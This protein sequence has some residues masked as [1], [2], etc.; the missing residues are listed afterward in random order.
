MR[1]GERCLRQPDPGSA[2][3]ESSRLE[4]CESDASARQPGEPFGRSGGVTVSISGQRCSRGTG[5][6][7]C[8]AKRTG[9]TGTF[10]FS[11]PRLAGSGEQTF[12]FPWGDGQSCAFDFR[13]E[14]FRAPYDAGAG[15]AAVTG[16][17]EFRGFEFE[18]EQFR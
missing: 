14:H 8:V 9:C 6:G 3:P 11:E 4:Q 12:S 15:A 10:G 1:S 7:V 5:T 2:L 16:C 18:F 13:T 17:G